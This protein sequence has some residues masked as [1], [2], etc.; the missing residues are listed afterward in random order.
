MKNKLILKES[1]DLYE[2][3][4]ALDKTGIGALAIVD[5]EDRLLGI[6]TDGDLRRAI[7]RKET[8]IENIINKSPAVL[9]YGTPKHTIISKLKELHRRH[10]PLVDKSGFFVEL[11]AIDNIDFVSRDNVVVIMAGG[12][13]TRLGKLTEHKPKPLL[14]VGDRPI[15][16]HMIEHARDQGFRNFLLCVNYKKELIYD[17]FGNGEKYGVNIRYI[18]ENKRMGTAGAL[19]LIPKALLEKP[20]FVVNGDVITN[21]DFDDLLVAHEKTNST[22]TMCVRSYSHEVPYGVIECK[23]NGEIIAIKEKP[24]YNFNINAGIYVID[25]EALK[26]LPSDT[27]YD[28]PQLFIDLKRKNF[29]IGS[30]SIDDYWIDIGKPQDYEQAQKLWSLIDGLI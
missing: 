30:Y 14:N 10:I 11:F 27:F 17:Y 16:R 9:L 4:E 3:V 29:E 6:L 25:P 21:L 26:V 13:G 28:M 5:R 8:K 20:F 18:E 7:L 19:S 23:K 2:V 24:Q 15:L 1:T 22:A 12:L